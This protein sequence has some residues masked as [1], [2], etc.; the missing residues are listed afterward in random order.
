MKGQDQGQV[1]DSGREIFST[2]AHNEPTLPKSQASSVTFATRKDTPIVVAFALKRKC[3]SNPNEDNF[4]NKNNKGKGNSRDKS[5][6][7]VAYTQVVNESARGMEESV[8]SGSIIIAREE[9]TVMVNKKAIDSIKSAAPEILLD[10]EATDHACSDSPLFDLIAYRRPKKIIVGNEYGT[11]VT[12][13][14]Q[15]NVFNES[16]RLVHFNRVLYC[17]DFQANVISVSQMART[18]GWKT[19]FA[20][21]SGVIT[22]SEGE[23]FARGF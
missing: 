20:N 14:G 4:R 21:D 19:K 6:K 18:A 16:E 12:R 15:I 1:L 13:V 8:E 3:Y 9:G 22:T 5:N 17:P 10:N 23:V 11:I 2:I 7:F